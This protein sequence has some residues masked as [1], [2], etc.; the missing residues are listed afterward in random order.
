MPAVSRTDFGRG[1]HTPF[2]IEP[3]GGKVGEDLPEPEADVSAD[4]LEENQGSSGVAD[5]PQDV[6][7]QVSGVV[8]AGSPAGVTERLARVAA[9]DKIHDATP[10]ARSEGA[11]I[12]MDRSLVHSTPAHRF[13]QVR[14]AEGFPLHVTD[15]SSTGDRQSDP[16]IKSSDAGAE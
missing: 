11:H 6:G 15:D 5:D 1:E 2:R 16:E 13:D 3:A 9:S 14:D 7:P 12:R 8:G 4:V 10:L